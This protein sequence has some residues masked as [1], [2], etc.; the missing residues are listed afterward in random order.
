MTKP[1]AVPPDAERVAIDYLVPALL[2]R[3]QDV[4]VG[5]NV[6]TA[7]V[8]GTKPHVRVAL[9]GTP[10]V[11]YPIMWR[12]S[13]RFTIWHDSTTTAKALAV[14]VQAIMCAHPGSTQVASVQPLTG[15]LPALDPDTKAQLASVSVRMNMLGQLV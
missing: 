6:P 9:D 8:K 3:S 1:V 7:W 15:V 14:L 10:E 12:A 13:V 2:S 5:V 4:T 11:Q